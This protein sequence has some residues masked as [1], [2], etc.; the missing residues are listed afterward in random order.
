MVSH[1]VKERMVLVSHSGVH[2]KDGFG[3]SQWYRMVFVRQRCI[4]R[5]VMVRHS[6]IERMVL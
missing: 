4:E 1:S 5:M 3:K 2:R 6:G